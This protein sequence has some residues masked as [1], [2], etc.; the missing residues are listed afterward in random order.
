[1]LFDVQVAERDGWEVATVVGDVD[2]ATLPRLWA[3]LE[4]LVSP[5]VAI[6]LQ[7]VAW[8]DPVCSGALVASA[9]RA[10]RRGGRLV[11]LGGTPV[12]SLLADT[13]LDQV[14]EVLDELPPSAGAPRSP[15]PSP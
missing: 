13:H 9:Q 7:A 8:F 4:P 1:V 2:L 5:N 14:I 11:V 10:R 12:S 15:R 6:D 3:A